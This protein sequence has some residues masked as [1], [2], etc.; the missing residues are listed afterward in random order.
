MMSVLQM[1]YRI[2][3]Y[4]NACVRSCAMVEVVNGK[5]CISSAFRSTISSSSTKPKN[6]DRKEWRREYSVDGA[7]TPRP[8]IS[9][10][11]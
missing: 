8:P 6:S 7:Q 3:I 5:A 1:K 10:I 11:R 2:Q 9:P 4:Q